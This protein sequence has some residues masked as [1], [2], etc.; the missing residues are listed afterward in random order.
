M[1]ATAT[2]TFRQSWSAPDY[3]TH[4][5]FVSD[6]AGP[7]LEWLSPESGEAILDLGCGDGKLTASLAARGAIVT[8][9]DSSPDFVAACR[10]QGLDAHLMDGQRLTLDAR[11][12][13]VFSNA[14]LH[15]MPDA[16]AVVAGVVRALKPGGRFVA[17]FGGHGNVAAIVTAMRAIGLQRGGN[18]DLANPWY[19][20]SPSAYQAVIERHGLR[21][22]RIG[23]FPRPTPLPTGMREWLRLFRKPFF[24]QFEKEEET[25]L[26]ETVELLRPALCD[27]AGQWSADYVR[28][29]VEAIKP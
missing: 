7:V 20:P 29:R 21:L 4:A 17:E 3:D 12:D 13:A 26:A 28:L 5:R 8:G 11:F 10:A 16:D 24:E 19:F 6:L 2:S 18:V 14:A 9:I 23:L 1:A 15:W 27:D 22:R 25:A